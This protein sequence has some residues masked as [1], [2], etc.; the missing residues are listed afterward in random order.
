MTVNASIDLKA[1]FRGWVRQRDRFAVAELRLEDVRPGEVVVRN[2]A[3]QACYTLA[4]FLPEGQRTGSDDETL[5]P[6]GGHNFG[7]ERAKSPG[8]GACGEVVAVGAGVRRVSVGDRVVTTV[9]PSCG[10]CYSCIRG[11]WA[12]CGRKNDIQW[13]DPNNP[14][15]ARLPDGTAVWQDHTGGFAELAV[16]QEAWVVPVNNSTLSDVELATLSCSPGSGWTFGLIGMPITIASTVAVIGAGP[17]G[18]AVIQ[19]ARMM[20]A[21]L[22]IAVDRIPT[23]MS[24]AADA[25][26]HVVLDADELDARV[27]DRIFELCGPATEN[28]AAGGKPF[29]GFYHGRG[30]DHVFEATG[31]TFGRPSTGLPRDPTGAA[32]VS[33]GVAA[34]RRGGTFVHTGWTAPTSD[35]AYWDPAPGPFDYHAKQYLS[36]S[37]GGGN[38]LRDVPRL[39]SLI[40]TRHLDASALCDP[41]LPFERADEALRHAL[42]RDRLLPIITYSGSGQ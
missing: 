28:M 9:L 8:H 34:T 16:C 14:P 4:E 37:Y 33:W 27:V 31:R 29:S 2:R 3:A 12:S 1:P 10:T 40:E 5:T 13:A 6:R 22:I 42:D 17:L 21:R 23:R 39:A 41:V 11:E 26:A 38:V 18:L 35:P 30:A 36:A 24:A 7:D 20:G 15:F 19:A 25:G 32:P